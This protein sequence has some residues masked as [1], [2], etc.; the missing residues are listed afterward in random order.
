MIV[1]SGRA[2]YNCIVSQIKE[3]V[4]RK[5]SSRS[6]VWKR[7]IHFTD[8]IKILRIN[9]WHK[10]WISR[11][12]KKSHLILVR[13][14]YHRTHSIYLSDS[15]YNTVKR[16]R[17]LTACWRVLLPIN[18]ENPDWISACEPFLWACSEAFIYLTP[19][20]ARQWIIVFFRP[21]CWAPL[22]FFQGIS[23]I[24]EARYN[25]LS[26]FVAHIHIDFS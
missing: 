7:L 4:G 19:R 21:L 13:S 5:C 8:C 18:G 25:R 9:T 22:I 12:Q 1:L 3:P 2:A 23:R 15:W 6:H 26:S 24:C 20:P 14:D 11:F 10:F 16:S 17:L